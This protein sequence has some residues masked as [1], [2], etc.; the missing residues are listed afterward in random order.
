MIPPNAL[1]ITYW[2][3]NAL[4]SLTMGIS[5][6]AYLTREPIRQEF[7]RIGFPSYFRIEFAIAKLIGVCVLLLPFPR[8]LKEWAYPGFAIDLVSAVIAHVANGD[9]LRK[10]MNPV[11]VG[12]NF[13]VLYL[14][15][16]RMPLNA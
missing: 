8:K 6:V 10:V 16:I 9:D 2:I 14:A 4:F 3:A 1:R 12:G 13:L 5:V 15:H 11:F 7:A